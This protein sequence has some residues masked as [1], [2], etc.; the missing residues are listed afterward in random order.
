MSIR[1]Y[2]R[3]YKNLY[4]GE[5][6]KNSAKVKWKLKHGAGQL[7]IYVITAAANEA[8]QL[9]VTHCAF[10]KQK[11]YKKHPAFVY[12]IAGSREEA[13]DLIVKISEEASACGMEGDLKGYLN[14]VLGE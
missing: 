10:L 4:V 13:F 9:E 12:G 7:L 1:G 11:Y 2:C 5:S 3:F 8:D 6:I 14:T